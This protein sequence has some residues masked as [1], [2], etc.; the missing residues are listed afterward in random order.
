[1]KEGWK[2]DRK[3]AMFDPMISNINKSLTELN[4]RKSGQQTKP[5]IH[6]YYI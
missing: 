4:I 5:E 6:S 1:M 3:S 2:D